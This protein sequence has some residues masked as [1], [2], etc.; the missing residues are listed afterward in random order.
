MQ[1][2]FTDSVIA[3]SE[4]DDVGGYLLTL[5]GEWPKLADT[6]KSSEKLIMFWLNALYNVYVNRNV[7]KVKLRYFFSNKALIIQE[8]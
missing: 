3:A 8:P 1:Q 4:Y 2:L 6:D 7:E 5:H